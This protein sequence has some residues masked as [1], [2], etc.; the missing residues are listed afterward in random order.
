M[1]NNMNSNNST[2]KVN[3]NMS[4]GGEEPPKIEL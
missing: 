4:E 1:I 3:D 2:D